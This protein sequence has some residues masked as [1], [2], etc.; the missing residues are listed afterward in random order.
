MK[1]DSFLDE[2]GEEKAN[3]ATGYAAA[4]RTKSQ[5]V[6]IDD[7]AFTDLTQAPPSPFEV[8]ISKHA[9]AQF[10]R[11]TENGKT[12][13]YFYDIS[14]D[15]ILGAGSS[16]QVNAAYRINSIQSS[17]NPEDKLAIK[18][19]NSFILDEAESSRSNQYH[20][21]RVELFPFDQSQYKYGDDEYFVFMAFI[22]GVNLAKNLALL[23]TLMPAQRASLAAQL[24][25]QMFTMHNHTQTTGQ[26]IAHKDLEPK[27]INLHING[28]DCDIFVLDYGEAQ[29]M[30]DG[31]ESSCAKIDIF[32][33]GDIMSL[34]FSRTTD[35]A[36]SKLE[37]QLKMMIDLGSKDYIN[38]ALAVKLFIYIMQSSRPE[39]RPN[40]AFVLRFFVWVK[41]FLQLRNNPPDTEDEQVLHKESLI[42][43]A[44]NLKCLVV[45]HRLLCDGDN[46]AEL[47]DDLLLL[48][49]CCTL[50]YHQTDIEML[51][52]KQS[53]NYFKQF[54]LLYFSGLLSA[55]KE[56]ATDTSDF[57]YEFRTGGQCYLMFEPLLKKGI[58][59]AVNKLINGR[60]ILVEMIDDQSTEAIDHARYTKLF[61]LGLLMDHAVESIYED[62][63]YGCFIRLLLDCKTKDEFFSS[64]RG[65][66]ST[67]F[68][69]LNDDFLN[70]ALALFLKIP[71]AFCLLEMASCTTAINQIRLIE[72]N[73]GKLLKVFSA[74]YLKDQLE[75]LH[76]GG[77]NNRARLYSSAQGDNDF[78]FPLIVTQN[79]VHPKKL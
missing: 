57:L 75:H 3:K 13:Y 5:L 65:R 74:Q 25:I 29:I 59:A 7:P 52:P 70:A 16:A 32:M 58:I 14:E 31:D 61:E 35:G 68:N 72:D 64:F 22:P 67:A 19:S 45:S 33:L 23:D 17:Y 27:N 54:K 21:H 2:T 76:R 63:K 28:T 15:G 79:T 24:A 73:K 56:A 43:Y 40:M 48:E 34:L 46:I 49:E 11:I 53:S 44:N 39:T 77:T 8:R 12:E 9:P 20:P 10:I 69:I 66:H 47:D 6:F 26:A 55:L 30:G 38:L 42:Y 18:Y 51:L 60:K 41:V 50:P 37:D 1:K 62:S 36:C 71:K 4:G 78:A